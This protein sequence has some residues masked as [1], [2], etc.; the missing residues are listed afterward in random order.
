MTILDQLEQVTAQEHTALV[1]GDWPTLVLCVE[2]KNLLAIEVSKLDPSQTTATQAQRVSAATRYNLELAAALSRRLGNLL[3][4]TQQKPTY[5][6]G[7]R[8][9]NRAQTMMSLRG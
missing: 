7:G 8:L 1:Q 9:N 2:Q 6:R 3:A 4:Q 5:D